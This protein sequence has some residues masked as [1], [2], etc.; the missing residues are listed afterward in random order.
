M[1]GT[2][3]TEPEDALLL[4]T[5]AICVIAIG[6]YVFLIVIFLLI[7]Q[8][9]MDRGMCGECK[10]VC[11]KEGEQ[12][13]CC[14][15]CITT[16]SQCDCKSPNCD[17]CVDSVCPKP[18]KCDCGKLVTCAWCA[19]KDCCAGEPLCNSGSCECA[20]SLPEC[21]TVECLCFRIQLRQPFDSSR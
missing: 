13:A 18:Q 14:Q 6:G 5:A 21:D 12:C 7:R 16:L 17:I 15:C 8:V 4:P 3:T 19:Q 10:H 20:C 9:L 2:P 1:E 11:G